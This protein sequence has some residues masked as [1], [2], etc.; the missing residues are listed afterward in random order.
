M[1]NGIP[2]KSV[3][4]KPAAAEVPQPTV[5]SEKTPN[6]AGKAPVE[7]NPDKLNSKLLTDTVQKQIPESS[8][9]KLN[10]KSTEN[11]QKLDSVQKVESV[12]KVSVESNLDKNSSKLATETAQKLNPEP[13]MDKLGNRLQPESI[14]KSVPEIP[15]ERIG[16]RLLENTQKVDRENTDT[17]KKSDKLDKVAALEKKLGNETDSIDGLADKADVKNDDL[18]NEAN[19]PAGKVANEDGS[20]RLGARVVDKN[21]RNDEKLP[22]QIAPLKDE[23]EPAPAGPSKLPVPNAPKPLYKIII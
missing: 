4:S 9:D 11:V 16:N 20:R 3:E 22:S 23:E 15:A 18:N 13:N 12:Q 2:A 8:L 6:V 14:Q 5:L 7:P 10:N 19:L 21:A 1:T 17:L